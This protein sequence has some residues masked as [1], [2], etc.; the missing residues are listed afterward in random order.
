MLMGEDINT[1]KKNRLQLDIN[2]EVGLEINIEFSRLR[3]CIHVSS[4]ECE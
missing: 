1:I 2:N 3:L 4:P